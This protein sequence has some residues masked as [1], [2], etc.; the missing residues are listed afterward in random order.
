[1]QNEM[2]SEDWTEVS[3]ED[4]AAL[5]SSGDDKEIWLIR[6]PKGVSAAALDGAHIPK[7]G[8]RVGTSVEVAGGKKYRISDVDTAVCRQYI[9]ASY[10]GGDQGY[11]LGKPFSRHLEVT[12]DFGF[13][14]AT[15]VPNINVTIP[16][17]VLDGLSDHFKP[18][19]AVPVAATEDPP[20]K[21]KKRKKR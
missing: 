6:L 8:K 5:D 19:G 9:S 20:K 10:R 13:E 1:M 21:A 18:L 12:E 16:A 15:S 14:D 17:A 7:R 2:P 3:G 4:L 11:R